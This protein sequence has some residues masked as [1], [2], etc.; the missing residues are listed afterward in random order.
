MTAFI[1]CD[2]VGSRIAGFTVWDSQGSRLYTTMAEV[3]ASESGDGAWAS[4]EEAMVY[5]SRMPEA[6]WG[7]FTEMVT[8]RY[9]DGASRSVREIGIRRTSTPW[10]RPCFD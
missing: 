7:D 3:V 1:Y 5:F 10:D 4:L 2:E 6:D 8:V 9:W